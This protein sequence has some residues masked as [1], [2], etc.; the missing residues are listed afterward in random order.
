MLPPTGVLLSPTGVIKNE[1]SL[2]WNAL[3]S[4]GVKKI[5]KTWSLNDNSP[6]IG[7]VKVFYNR[8]CYDDL[9]NEYGDNKLVLIMGTPGIGKTM[10]LQRIL[11]DIVE[12]CDGNY[13]NLPVVDYVTRDLQ[14]VVVYR[15][16]SNGTVTIGDVNE[17]DYVLSDSVDIHHPR[18]KTCTILVASDKDSNY[19]EFD[20]RISE[21]KGFKTMMPLC[22]LVELTVMNPTLSIDEAVFR[23]D[24]YGG[25]ARNF[26]RSWV[27]SN[28]EIAFVEE[29]ML[30]YFG[31]NLKAQHSQT[32]QA[33]VSVISAEFGKAIDKKYNVLN[34]LMRHRDKNMTPLWASKFMKVLASII[35]E[36]KEA[37]M[38]DAVAQ[39]VGNAALGH[40]FEEFAHRKLT[41][42]TETFTLTPLYP[43]HQKNVSRESV[44]L[45]LRGK[46]IAFL[47]DVN[48]ISDLPENSYGL[49][50]TLQFPLVDSIV[51]PDLLFQMTVSSDHSGAVDQLGDIRSRLKEKDQ[52][53]HRMIFVVPKANTKSFPYQG[54]LLD[55]KQ[56]TLCPDTIGKKRKMSN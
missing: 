9:I 56:F 31:P 8:E 29:T 55:I 25:S 5:G 21:G 17:V 39:L 40:F 33:V 4:G 53:K 27:S 7:G 18:G 23:Y 15:L 35:Y 45:D 10:F 19:N 32:W 38:Y 37:S 2:F 1:F 36:K 51:Q 13:A 48:D 46:T 20:K 54:N 16:N 47:R 44:T 34:S 41:S 49:P 24:V 12:K 11:V 3:L 42:S 14:G 52:S 6:W 26:N 43:K 50:V 28:V 22:T 30:W